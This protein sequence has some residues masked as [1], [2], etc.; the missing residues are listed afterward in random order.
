MSKIIKIQIFVF[1]NYSE[2]IA[3]NHLKI[4][5]AAM[6]LTQLKRFIFKWL[7]NWLNVYSTEYFNDS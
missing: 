5:V 2:T 6:D 3:I 1:K 4:A 7:H